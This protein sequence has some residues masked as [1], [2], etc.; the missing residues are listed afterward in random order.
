VSSL[1]PRAFAWRGGVG[2][3]GGDAFI[4]SQT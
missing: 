3:L 4:A 1:A 2:F